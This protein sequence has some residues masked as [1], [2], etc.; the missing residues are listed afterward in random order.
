MGIDV[1]WILLDTSF[2]NRLSSCYTIECSS[3]L[4]IFLKVAFFYDGFSQ[5]AVLMHYVYHS[6]IGFQ[7]K[8]K[9]L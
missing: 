2:V 3:T 7:T 9:K 1:P 6:G 8:I 4:K 5:L